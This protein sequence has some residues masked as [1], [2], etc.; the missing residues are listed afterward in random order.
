VGPGRLSALR[1]HLPRGAR[2]GGPDVDRGVGDAAGRGGGRP[3]AQHGRRRQHGEDTDAE[4]TQHDLALAVDIGELAAQWAREG[5]GQE[6]RRQQPA[7]LGRP[8]LRGDGGEC[9][10]DDRVPE[11]HR[12]EEQDHDD[13]GDHDFGRPTV[14][15]RDSGRACSP[16]NSRRSVLWPW[17]RVPDAGLDRP[18]SAVVAR[19]RCGTVRALRRGPAVVIPVTGTPPARRV[20]A[21]R[22]RRW[23][24]VL[25]APT[26]ALD[27]PFDATRRAGRHR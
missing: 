16:S 4:H 11:R 21:H 10:G 8:E 17:A 27:A 3:A 7:T 6:V 18:G 23:E 14:P 25:P 12:L 9:R 13:R 1:A 26:V 22:E 5:T 24:R 20:P 15:G 2:G 19:H